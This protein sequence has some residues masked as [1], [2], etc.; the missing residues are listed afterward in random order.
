MLARPLRI[1]AGALFAALALGCG[2]P[3]AADPPTRPAPLVVIGIDGGEWRVV[4]RL[5]E[6]GE[7]PHLR[8]LAE[9]GA[10]ASLGTAYNSSPVIWTTIATGVVPERHGITD[11]VVAT[12]AGDVPISSTVRRVPALWNMATRAGRRAA[13]LGW[14]GSWP[15]EEDVAGI[16]WSDRILLGLGREVAPAAE[17]ARLLEIAAEIEREP[18]RF[19]PASEPERR[20]AVMARAAERAVREPFELVLVYFRSPDIVSHGSWHGWAP[21]AF[22][23][24]DA[25]EIE[26]ARGE[27]ERIYGAVDDAIGRLVEAAPPGSDFL[28]VSDHGFRA[29]AGGQTRVLLDFDAVLERLGYLERL[30]AGADR[31]EAAGQPAGIDFARTRFYSYASPD[32]RPKFVRFSLAGREPG[33]AVRADQRERLRRE[34]EADLE[35]VRYEGGDPV[36]Q[37]RDAKPVERERGA[38]FVVLVRRH[39]ATRRLLI[40][41]EPESKLFAD[42]HRLTGTHGT[43][44]DGLLIAAGPAIAAG[45]ALDG[46]HIHD[47]APT[48]LYRLGLPVA[49]DFA[50]AARRDLYTA[51]FRA[52]HPLRSIESWGERS[53]DGPSSSPADAKLLAELRGLGYIN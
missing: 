49:A 45:S 35:R 22:P 20:D 38:D 13:V 31:A 36:F 47:L 52:R 4:R 53:A 25:A 34:L 6:R 46:I 24:F 44:N 2:G 29:E 10:S 37:V 26:A 27:V 21:E 12:P 43:S 40:G 19:R 8:A 33:G 42:V 48:I 17:Q 51:E 23:E 32:F 5:W 41:G 18:G 16:V 3:T 15:A 7:L 28:V 14:W 39:G 1:G 50:G 30:P 9:R 11:F